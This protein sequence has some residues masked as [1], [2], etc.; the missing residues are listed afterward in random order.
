M[1]GDSPMKGQSPF[2]GVDMSKK[3]SINE[4][5]DVVKNHKHWINEDCPN[6]ETMRANLRGADL[7]EA[8]L[9]GADLSEAD[10]SEADLYGAD[11]CGAYLRGANLYGADL[12]GANLYGANLCGADLRRADLSEADLRGANLYGANLYGANLSKA[13]LRGANLYRAYLYKVNL[14][15][16]ENV[17]SICPSEG[18]FIGWKKAIHPSGDVVIIKLEI[19]ADAKRSNG[20]GRKCRCSKAKVLGIYDL[21]DNSLN[22][23]YS[24]YDASF[25]Y[26]TGDI[27]V[28]DSYDEDRW[29]ECSNGIHFFITKYEALNYK[30][31]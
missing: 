22:E 19:P 24:F 1:L 25:V 31:N 15:G 30:L 18:S 11:L 7:S 26:H 17:L 28:P 21:Y 27:V 4:L 3:I 12:R 5:N 16:Y 20:M 6:W 9:Y 14:D 8:D 23:A 2:G 29:N 10:L 13:D